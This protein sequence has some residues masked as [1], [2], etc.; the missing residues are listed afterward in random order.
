VGFLALAKACADLRARKAHF[1]IVEA[2]DSWLSPKRLK[3][4]DMAG[5]THSVNSSWGFIPGEGAGCCLVTTGARA[6]QLGLVPLAE[7]LGVGIAHETK[8]MGTETVC[9]GEGLTKAFRQVLDS[10]YRVSH[11][12][13]DFN[14]ET[15]RADEYGFTICRTSK[16]FED[17]SRFTAAAECWGDV[18]AASGLVALTLPLSVWT[19]ENV[20]LVWSS[21]A[22]T[23]LRGAALLKQAAISN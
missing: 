22:S 11:C 6:K 18:G 9:I 20:T 10:R 1:C 23:P 12:Y 16:Y 17:S 2:A 3:A 7:V 13:C 19:R 14:G 15:Y 5:R 8:L 4:V 21:G